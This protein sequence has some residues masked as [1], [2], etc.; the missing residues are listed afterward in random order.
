MQ[1]GCILTCLGFSMKARVKSRLGNCYISPGLTQ[2]SRENHH[3]SG[4]IAIRPYYMLRLCVSP[5][6]LQ[7]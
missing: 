6:P 5:V 7:A 3:L 2:I 4:R 1:K